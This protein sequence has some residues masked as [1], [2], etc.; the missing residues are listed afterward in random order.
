VISAAY[1]RGAGASPDRASRPGPLWVVPAALFFAAFAVAPLI[2]VV[3]LSFASW[4]GV[5]SPKLTGAGNW[6]RLLSDGTVA[7][8]LKLSVVLTVLAWAVQTALALPL[9]VWAA[10]RQRNRAVLSS[11][12]MIPLLLSS[13]AIALIFLQLLDPNFG[14]PA[15]LGPG[16]GFSPNAILGSGAGAMGAVVFVVSWQFIPF[17][18]LLY[19]AGARQVPQMLYDAAV[20]D[21][22]G[23]AQQF[24]RVT[25]PQLRHTIATSSV[26]IVVGSLTYFDTVLVLTQGG[27]GTSTSILPYHMY[28]SG[29]KAYEMGYASAIAVGLVVIGSAVSLLIV[30]F[31]GFASMRSTLEGV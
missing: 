21:G 12:F 7:S 13:V 9:G 18:L 6:T 15:W 4:N 16:L 24:F 20:I 3:V 2:L 30:R 5:A 17:H 27:P 25:L 1:Q 11:I 10:G 23:R 31:S 26:L 19:Q 22:A 28:E 29:F 14:L 8:S